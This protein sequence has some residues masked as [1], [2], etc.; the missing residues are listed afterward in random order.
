MRILNQFPNSRLRALFG[1]ERSALG[2]LLEAGLPALMSRRVAMQQSKPNRRRQVGGGRRG[3]AGRRRPSDHDEAGRIR[4]GELIGRAARRGDDN[5]PG[6]QC[7]IR[8]HIH[9]SHQA[10]AIRVHGNIRCDD[11]RVRRAIQ[12]EL[13]FGSVDKAGEKVTETWWHPEWKK[14]RSLIWSGIFKRG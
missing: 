4:R 1:L 7:G 14:F 2:L 9:R 6:P 5:D 8:R 13:E 12:Q 3:G 11:A 10:C